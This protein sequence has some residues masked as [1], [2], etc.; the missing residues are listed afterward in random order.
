MAELLAAARARL[1]DEGASQLS[2]RAVARDLGMA[3]SAVYRYV[4]SRDALLTL[5]I[6]DAYDAVGEVAETAYATARAAES[7]APT[8]WLEVARA[9]RRW[10]LTDR[11]AYELVYGTPV[12]RYE[13]PQDTVRA[14]QRLW[15][16]IAAV[17]AQAQTDGALGSTG[18]APAPELLRN[19]VDP[20]VLEFAGLRSDAPTSDPERTA[21]VARALSLFTSL[22]GAVSAELFGHFH[23][24]TVD[25]A[26]AFDVIVAAGAAG[27]G[28]LIR[29][30][31]LGRA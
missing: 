18:P 5:L 15:G 7:D 6:I 2:L 27:V 29:G 21:D 14:A 11:H 9:V 24:V 31:L 28:L 3:S 30:E 22:T 10:G 8:A 1:A 19:L 25:S 17:L 16:V 4:P 20:R 12:P 23:R 26:L 13:A